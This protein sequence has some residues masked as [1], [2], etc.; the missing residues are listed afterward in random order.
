VRAAHEEPGDPES[1]SLTGHT[2]RKTVPQVI[3]LFAAKA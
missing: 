3:S 2:P 1:E